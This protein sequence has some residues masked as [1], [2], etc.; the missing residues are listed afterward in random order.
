MPIPILIG[1][2][3]AVA[4]AAG[5]GAGVYGGAKFYGAT[6]LMKAAQDRNDRN[7]RRYTRQQ[8]QTVR[9]MDR[10]GSLELEI[11]HSFSRFSDLI[12]Q[13]Q[14]RP[15]FKEITIGGMTL[16]QYSPA[17]LRDVSVGAGVLL[18]ALGG[19]AAGAAGGFAAAG[20]TTAAVA[21]LASAGTGAA[22]SSLSGAAATNAVLAVLGGGTIAAGGGG[23]A[24]GSVVLGSAAAGVGLIV[25]GFIFAAAG[26]KMSDKAEEA[27]AE[28]EKAEKIVNKLCSYLS[29]LDTTAGSYRGT[30]TRVYALYK[31]LLSRLASV[32]ASKKDWNRFSPSDR[33][34]TEN[35]VKLVTVLYAM[36]KVNLVV[37][38]H[39]PNG[40]NKVNASDVKKN[41]GA[42]EA[43][44]R[45]LQ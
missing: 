29:E 13:I 44:L 45:Q 39:D 19:A 35:L 27:M 9:T 24:L 31:R 12:E 43:L 8:E 25:G 14:N 18:G 32:L 34:L 20:A 10:L 42:G 15:Q 41:Q 28:V 5:V 22:I 23:M 6:Q 1:A 11:V 40:I 37:Q 16:P 33:Q 36:C 4:A 38:T 21:A 26:S 2:A 30:L 7:T 17:E 3:A